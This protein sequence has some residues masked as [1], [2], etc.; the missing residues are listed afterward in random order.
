[1]NY[2]DLEH[3]VHVLAVSPEPA[4]PQRQH[5]REL[6]VLEGRSAPGVFVARPLAPTRGPCGA[7][8]GDGLSGTSGAFLLA[9]RRRF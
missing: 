2:Q 8:L 7:R 1:M 3:G 4:S 9:A 6:G 5:P